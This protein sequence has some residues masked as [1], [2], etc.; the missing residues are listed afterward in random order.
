MRTKVPRQVLSGGIAVLGL[1]LPNLPPPAAAYQRP[2]LTERVSVRSDGSDPGTD[3][4]N[5]LSSHVSRNGRYVIFETDE[6]LVPEDRGG[7]DIYL[8]DR[9]TGK[10]KLVSVGSDA[11]QGTL[12]NVAGSW[13]PAVTPDGRY[14]AFQTFNPLVPADTN[15]ATDVYVR[16]VKRGSTERVSVHSNGNQTMMPLDD[17]HSVEP[18]ISDDGRYVAFNSGASD[19]VD[20]DTNDR[21][22]IFVHDRRTRDT[23]RVSV[24]NDG[25]EAEGTSGWSNISGNGRYVV[26]HNGDRTLDPDHEPV[27]AGLFVRDLKTDT[28]EWATEG[29]IP[30]NDGKAVSY[31]G[32]FITFNS[33]WNYFVP[34]DTNPMPLWGTDIFVFDRKTRRHE[35]VSVTSYGEESE[36][37]STDTKISGNGRYVS[38]E[39]QADNLFEGEDTSP[40]P[41]PQTDHDAFVHDRLTGLTEMV[42]VDPDGR[43]TPECPGIRSISQA[44]FDPAVSWDGRYVS[45]VSCSD[46]LDKDPRN[47]SSDIY[48]RDRG[49]TAGVRGWGT[50]DALQPP[51]EGW[52]RLSKRG[53]GVIKDS[54]SDVASEGSGRG[55]EILW[56]TVAYRPHLSDIYVKIDV[57]RMPGARG[58]I[59]G[60]PAAGD[61]A[62]IYG[63]RLTAKDAIYEARI[64]KQEAAGVGGEPVFGL[65]S[66]DL[67][68][69]SGTAATDAIGLP[70]TANCTEERRLRGGYGTVGESVVTGIPLSSLGLRP[71]DRLEDI[72]VFTAMG[73]YGTGVL[74]VLDTAR[75]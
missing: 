7:T 3:T 27:F 69:R 55:A 14:V 25:S 34:N 13:N 21:P 57:D 73:S 50:R 37:S 70:G 24:A 66:C 30:D 36:N 8:R 65:F 61:P 35:R 26:F 63:V 72:E 19:L 29:G 4:G 31:D 1:I 67:D 59:D 38:F 32:R 11:T 64:A 15:V 68:M 42:S 71:G 41:W 5:W 17:H 2:G 20:D 40:E 45:F 56:A 46:G 52:T 51:I 74:R 33:F 39:S 22:D 9:K 49:P 62:I 54:D 16:D 12:P 28:T 48:V 58:G 75:P 10:T 6:V 18:S 43:Q 53:A 44:A 60:V 23:I 47:Q